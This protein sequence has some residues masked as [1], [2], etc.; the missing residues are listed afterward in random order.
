MARDYSTDDSENVIQTIAQMDLSMRSILIGII[1]SIRT[2]EDLYILEMENGTYYKFNTPRE[3][4]SHWKGLNLSEVIRFI[5]DKKE[6]IFLM[7]GKSFYYI[8][9]KGSLTGKSKK[10]KNDVIADGGSIEEIKPHNVFE[11]LLDLP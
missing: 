9:W 6:N 11:E 3:L 8:C 4:L 10:I 5:V 2:S 7:H 1:R